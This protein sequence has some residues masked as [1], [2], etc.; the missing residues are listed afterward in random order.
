MEFLVSIQEYFSDFY[1]NERPGETHI[2]FSLDLNAWNNLL[3][4]FR[5]G[6]M[7]QVKGT[8][9]LVKEKFSF[10]FDIDGNGLVK[11]LVYDFYN[12]DNDEKIIQ[13]F[14]MDD[15]NLLQ[16]PN[17]S[18]TWMGGS[19]EK[20]SEEVFAVDVLYMSR[21]SAPNRLNGFKT[22]ES[23]VNSQESS[24]LKK[25]LGLDLRNKLRVNY[26]VFPS[27]NNSE[28]AK[29]LYESAPQKQYA[30]IVGDFSSGQS[31]TF[32]NYLQEANIQVPM[33]S[34]SATASFL[35]PVGD[36]PY[37]V[38]MAQS[39]S[40]QGLALGFVMKYFNWQ[41]VCVMYQ[42][43]AYGQGLYEIFVD[44][45][46]QN[47]IEILNPISQRSGKKDFVDEGEN[48]L[49]LEALIA[50]RTENCR[51]FAYFGVYPFIKDVFEIQHD[52]GLYGDN[53]VQVATEWLGSWK[54]DLEN[55]EEKDIKAA[56]VLKGSIGVFPPDIIGSLGAQVKDKV[57][58]LY[59]AYDNFA[60]YSFDAGVMVTKV[61]A[62]LNERGDDIQSRDKFVECIR[63]QA[64]TASTGF[65]RLVD[66][67]NDRASIGFK[68]Y[69][70]Q[71]DTIH[72][73]NYDPASSEILSLFS[74]IIWPDDSTSTPADFHEI[75]ESCPFYFDEVDQTI[76]D[77]PQMLFICAISLLLILIICIQS[78]KH[79]PNNYPQLMHRG[80]VCLFDMVLVASIVAESGLILS[81]APS[82][83]FFDENVKQ[84]AGMSSVLYTWGFGVACMFACALCGIY[85]IS[86]C[87]LIAYRKITGNH[88]T[89]P[90]EVKYGIP[91]DPILFA[92][93][94][95]G[96]FF[97]A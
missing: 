22:V 69:N 80:R 14:T 23:M 11:E 89:V 63:E 37:F 4:K 9:D 47:E 30:I 77:R 43:T 6:F 68:I 91:T 72:V 39:D 78:F 28:E 61:I 66:G 56:K 19:L 2:D 75:D 52:L 87:I 15:G 79:P 64:F 44:S 96:F 36:Y 73:G 41:K 25:L 1:L 24:E 49:M 62:K 83:G 10:Y 35:A 82:F 46:N 29:A 13:A 74:S 71:H 18:Y 85:V 16:V 70:V 60:F 40:Q 59:G 92:M 31:R 94:Y 17:I 32:Y 93:Y 33:V 84:Y 3:S 55:P 51:I 21:K 54:P 81:F 8:P 58:E 34:V 95:M 5:A 86:C 88:G 76:T 45:A 20:P 57:Q 7:D 50:M 38:R 65:F 12:L 97:L 67:T 90:P 27:I 48:H 42:D 53:F 26:H